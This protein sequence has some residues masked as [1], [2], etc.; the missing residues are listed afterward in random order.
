MKDI[1]SNVNVSHYVNWQ[2]VYSRSYYRNN[3]FATETRYQQKSMSAAT[4]GS[5]YNTD[6]C[7]AAPLRPACEA[8]WR[9][10]RQRL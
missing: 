8:E 5:L 9:C 10:Q 3:D 4:A 7:A 6:G 1:F 2:L